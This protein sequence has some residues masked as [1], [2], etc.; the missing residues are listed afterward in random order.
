MLTVQILINDIVVRR[1]SCRRIPGPSLNM[2]KSTFNYITDSGDILIHN[3]DDGAVVLA[4]K[5][6][7]KYLEE[8][9]K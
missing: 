9:C 8:P 3:Y 1:L 7:A 4:K 2:E 5:L 6:I